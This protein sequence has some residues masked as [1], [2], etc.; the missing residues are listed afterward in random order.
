MS[1]DRRMDYKE[2]VHIYNGIV[3]SHKKGHSNAICGNTDATRD[4]Y[5][6]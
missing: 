1:F 3:L 2:V 5:T 6:K 4:S